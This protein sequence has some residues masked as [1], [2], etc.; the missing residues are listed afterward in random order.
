VLDALVMILA[1]GRGVVEVNTRVRSD[2]VLQAAF[3]RE[4]CADQS[5]VSATLNA[6]TRDNVA[7][8]RGALKDILQQH[9]RACEHD[10]AARYQVLDIDMSGLVLQRKVG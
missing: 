9:S 1:G 8:L 5:T 6:C 10:Y 2:G 4:G 7:Q 3:G